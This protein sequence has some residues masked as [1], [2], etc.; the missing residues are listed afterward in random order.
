MRLRRR[1]WE[2][3]VRSGVAYSVPL[4]PVT[5]VSGHYGVGKT[6][7]ALNMAVD[8]ANEGAAVTLVDLDVVNPYF[9]SSEYRDLAEG[10]G[11]KL[12]APVFGEAGRALTLLRLREPSRPRSR[13]RTG[14][15]RRHRRCRRRRR[16]LDC[17]RALLGGG[18]RRR[19]RPAFMS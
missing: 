1:V 16:G 8:V 14:G 6:T 5:L 15:G 19:I 11:V 3:Q 9:R 2:R 12:I 4:R 17:A 18:V 10:H 7:F 13:K